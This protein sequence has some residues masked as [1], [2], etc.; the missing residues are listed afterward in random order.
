MSSNE[1][2][3]S[4]R[5]E[6]DR[7]QSP[8]DAVDASSSRCPRL[9]D[10]AALIRSGE[11]E[12]A[13]E[14]CRLLDQASPDNPRV[15][16]SLGEIAY[17]RGDYPLAAEILSRVI[18]LDPQNAKYHAQLGTAF[19]R[20]GRHDEAITAFRRAIA[21]NPRYFAAY[22]RLAAALKD[23]RQIDD[24]ADTLRQA[25]RIRPGAF[26]TWDTFGGLLKSRGRFD[27]AAA[28]F[29]RAIEAA[30]EFARAHRNLG[31]VLMR[32]RKY[33]EAMYA[34]R[35]AIAVDHDDVQA[36][37][38]L[39]NAY[40]GQSLTAEAIE[41][42]SRALE[43]A[44]DSAAAR[45]GLC[46][47][48]LPII[49][50]HEAGVD[51]ARTA[52]GQQLGALHAYYADKPDAVL[53]EAANAI[54]LSQP[55]FL[56]Y[57]G[58][59]DRDLQALYGRMVC[60]VMAAAYPRWNGPPPRPEPEGNGRIR[61]GIVSGFFHGHSNWKIPIRGWAEHLDRR[62]FKLFAYYTQMRQDS[63]TK[64]GEQTFDRFR[65]GPRTFSGW[66]EAIRRDD[67]HV[68]IFPEIGM[69]PITAKL[70]ALRLAPVQCSSWGHPNTSGYPTID[71]FL[72]SDLME[73]P[74]GRDHYTETLVRLP[75]LSIHY[76]PPLLQEAII[77]RPVPGVRDGAVVY[78]CCQSL[79]K[80]VPRY[81]DIFP[82]IAEKVGDCQFVFLR[83]ASNSVTATFQA[84]LERAFAAHGLRWDRYCVLSE[85]LSA[86]QFAAAMRT[87]DVFLDSVG[88]SGCNTTLEACAAAL[89]VVTCRGETMRARHSAA[90][91]EMM[92][93]TEC[94]VDTIDDYV[95]QAARM[96]MEP[97]WR[98]DVRKKMVER[99]HRA[100]E[101]RACIEG[102]EA[103]LL[104]VSGEAIR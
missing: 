70:A 58:R 48:Q 77:T 22:H 24:A 96:G 60:K 92:G 9:A 91:M 81:D 34:L 27:E 40:V 78:W 55:F 69:D 74:D 17:R 82:R 83:H 16:H 42:Y 41:E 66:C 33:E 19:S 85:R 54:G 1:P 79:F 3:P 61:V 10:I 94:V 63:A 15:L 7:N 14:M 75:N 2:A 35:S 43:L 103:F 65:R 4:E 18:R 36:R 28:A 5:P 99:R 62:R 86:A 25:L 26:E 102:L 49:Y 57:Q 87:A 89:P 90:I 84:R 50:D 53:A 97:A 38:H 20:A 37:C 12:A 30:P 23:A 45:F 59:V 31:L 104:R 21:I 29:G 71:Y 72:S 80:Y 8:R 101:D 98:M 93:M 51:A 39:A 76:T 52:Y 13:T 11:L 68:L 88:W 73:P 47:A 6:Q 46:M 95:T 44:P 64:Q 67:P 32:Q 56:A 100:W